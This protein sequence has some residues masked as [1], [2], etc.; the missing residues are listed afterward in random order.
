MIFLPPPATYGSGREIVGLRT[1][2]GVRLSALYLPNPSG[3]H[4]L[5]YSHGNAEDLGG[6]Y[7]L[8]VRLREIGFSVLAYDYRGYG[9]SEGKPSER[10]AYA[11]IDAAYAYLTT[12]LGIPPGHI[13]AYGRSVGAG[14]AV[15]LAARRP[16]GGLVLESAFTTALR[17][18]TRV[19]L[20]PFDRFRNIDKIGRVGCPVLVMHGRADEVVPFAHGLALWRA[21]PEPKRFLWVDGAGHND[22]WL[23]AGREAA[24]ALG[25]LAALV[26]TRP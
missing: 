21:A 9:T 7:P 16:I 24:R 6:V 13:I 1:A 11:D 26:G 4:T 14:P 22:F 19:P 20:L 5:L 8:L 18:I 17:V 10:G 25:E 15:D 23:V 12:T 3:D 2:D